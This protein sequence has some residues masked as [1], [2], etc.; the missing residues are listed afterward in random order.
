[1]PHVF[2]ELLWILIESCV[3][4]SILAAV[5][6]GGHVLLE[7]VPGVAKTLM[8]RCLAKTISCD[9]GRIQ[10]TPDLMPSDITGVMAY[11]PGTGDFYYKEGPVFTNIL[12]ADEINRAPAKVQAGLLE[13]MQERQVTISGTT[14][15]TKEPYLA[16]A[17][18]NPIE[19]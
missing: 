4:D 15:K 9:F 16:L 19:H 12:L 1:M 10:I 11:R 2:V 14:F 7:G 8:V 6:T 17:T 18:Q 5:L 3:L 13:V